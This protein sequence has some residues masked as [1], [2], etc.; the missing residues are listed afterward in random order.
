MSTTRDEATRRMDKAMKYLRLFLQDTPELNRLIRDYELDD[1]ELRFAI[2]MA[3]SDYN[4]TLPPTPV[5]TILNYPSLYLLMHG[6]A[7][8]AL[9]MAGIRQSRNQLDYQSG[10]SS[11]SRSN[12]TGLYQSWLSLFINEYEQKKKNFKLAQNVRRGYGEV[13]SEYD[14]VGFW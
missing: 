9:K 1:E 13:F 6:A 5:K 8:N 4:T 10:G 3:I 2:D 7:V 14:Y 11:F 12:K